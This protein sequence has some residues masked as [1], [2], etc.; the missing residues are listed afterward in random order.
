MRKLSY[1]LLAAAGALPFVAGRWIERSRR[2][3][4]ALHAI[5]VEGMGFLGPILICVLTMFV[6][7][8]VAAS[9]AALAYQKIERPRPVWRTVEL[10]TFLALPPVL[11][12]FTYL[13]ILGRAG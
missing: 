12:L 11:L 13:V 7:L 10:V 4:E 9:M 6:L 5:P 2:E 3:Y 8:V 1:L